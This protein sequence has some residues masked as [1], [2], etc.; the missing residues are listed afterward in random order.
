MIKNS[1][2]V[3]IKLIVCKRELCIFSYRAILHIGTNYQFSCMNENEDV[4]I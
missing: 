2:N 1:W 3:A 4:D